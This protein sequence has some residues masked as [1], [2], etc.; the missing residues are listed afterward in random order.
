MIAVTQG[1]NEC[2]TFAECSAFLADGQTIAYQ[3]AV[4]GPLNLIEVREGGGEPSRG[5]IETSVWR[6]GEFVS[7]G[8]VAGDLVG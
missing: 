8:T 5:I 7:T 3:S 2:T 6:G 1:D 4:G